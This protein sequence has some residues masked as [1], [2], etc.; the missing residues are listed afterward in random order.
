M[1]PITEMLVI[2][3]LFFSYF[4]LII[5]NANIFKGVHRRL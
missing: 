5:V 1:N 3:K 2:L 4:N